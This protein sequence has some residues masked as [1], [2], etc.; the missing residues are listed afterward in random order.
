MKGKAQHH[1]KKSHHA[2]ARHESAGGDGNRFNVGRQP[3]Y[4]NELHGSAF[5]NRINR[6]PILVEIQTFKTHINTYLK[7]MVLN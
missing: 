2:C 7:P 5:I 1:Q 6:K 3:G 4:P